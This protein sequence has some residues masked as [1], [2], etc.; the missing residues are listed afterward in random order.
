MKRLILSI[1]LS[2]AFFS[3]LSAQSN[4]ICR[5]G[6]TYETSRS[7]NWGME[8][9]IITSITPF[10]PAEK[11]GLK[12]GDIIMSIDDVNTSEVAPKDIEALMN[13]NDRD[14]IILTISNLKNP[15]RQVMVKKDC[16]TIAALTEEQ[17]A[18]AF[19]MY[20]LETNCDR[21]FTCPFKTSSTTD[22]VNFAHYKT[23]AFAAID[24]NNSKLE[25]TINGYIEKALLDKGLKV[26][27]ENPD[28]IIQTFYFFDK[29]PN[30]SPT[31]K[32][33]N[34]EKNYI[35]RYDSDKQ[36]VLSFPFLFSMQAETEAPFLLQFG[37]RM[38][39]QK[40]VKGRVLWECEANELLESSY[41]VDEYARIHVPLMLMQ[42]PYLKYPR[43]VKFHVVTKDFNYTGINYDIDHMNIIA[44]VDS[45]SPASH[46]GIV[47][48]DIIEK[49]NSCKMDHTAE[50]F[51][52]AYKAFITGSMKYRD[53]TTKFSDS[54]GFPRCMYWDKFKYT[55]VADAMA[56][57][58]NLAGFSYLYQDAPYIDPTGNNIIT[59]ILRRDKERPEFNIHPIVKK[60]LTVEVY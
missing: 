56:N 28:F 55:Q 26:N 60:S 43:I 32:V 52:A 2:V 7:I 58:V 6:F 57:P 15:S 19:Y 24:P 11:V 30:Y 27:S 16:K 1:L 54:N 37:F 59:F 5:L 38:I 33:P 22:A 8:R 29:N 35:Y 47:K 9:P 3:G 34:E 45:D 42:Y 17:L 53:T 13:P 48:G 50:E 40:G 51:S 4:M 31:A 20:S 23:F 10:S 49:I 46:A 12:P 39:D 36:K 25:T 41:R 18:T 44:S 21:T 14:A